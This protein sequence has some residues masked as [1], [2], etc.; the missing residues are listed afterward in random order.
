MP[1][2]YQAPRHEA[3]GMEAWKGGGGHVSPAHRSQS[4]RLP[5]PPAHLSHPS[6][7]HAGETGRR[8]L[9]RT[10]TSLP[11]QTHLG[12]PGLRGRDK[13]TPKKKSYTPRYVKSPTADV[14]GIPAPSS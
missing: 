8:H 10:P 13:R 7:V 4:T 12:H 3:W 6:R 14:R 11:E 9:R 1:V 5:C 2:W